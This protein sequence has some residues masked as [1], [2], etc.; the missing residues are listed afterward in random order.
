MAEYKVTF[1]LIHKKKKY[2]PGESVSM[3]EEL[4]APLLANKTLATEK[5]AGMN[6][7]DTIAKVKI[8]ETLEALEELSA[9]EERKSVVAAIEARRKELTPGGDE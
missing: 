4:A 6:A 5:P 9:G 2:M 7:A 1:P 8:A 3:D